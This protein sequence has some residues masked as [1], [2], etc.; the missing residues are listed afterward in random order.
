MVLMPTTMASSGGILKKELSEM[1]ELLMSLMQ[2]QGNKFNTM[3]S[4]FSLC[5]EKLGWIISN[6][7]TLSSDSV[8]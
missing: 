1:D 7:D 3:E 8:R 4:T 6:W 5:E 2:T